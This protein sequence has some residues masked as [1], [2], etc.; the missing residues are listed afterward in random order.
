MTLVFCPSAKAAGGGDRILQSE[1]KQQQIRSTTQR[2]NDQLAAIVGE[3]ERNGIG[4]EDVGV[5]KSIQ[6]V[7]GHLSEKEMAKIVDMLQ[8]ARSA[9]DPNAARRRLLDADSGQKN[10]IVKLKQLM[11]EYKRQQALFDLSMRFAQLAE[12]Q[13]LNMKEAIWLESLVR[14][15]T[16]DR[17]EEAQQ[18]PWRQQVIN[19]EAIR[20][21]VKLALARLD[22]LI[23]QADSASMDRAKAAKHLA[24]NGR[25]EPYLEATLTDLNGGRILSAAGMEKRG[26]DLLREISQQLAPPKDVV[27]ALKRALRELEQAII[28]QTAIIKMTEQLGKKLQE[29]A[30][31]AE[32]QLS[33]SDR[34]DTIRDGVLNSAPSAAAT[35]KE[36]VGK[37]QDAH[38]VL[39][40][41][42]A[43]W[44]GSE[45]KREEKAA[46]D[47]LES[48]RAQLKQQ[49][50]KAE[51]DAK[52]EQ[53]ALA[54]VQDL[55]KQVRA[56]I[57]DQ[58][59]LKEESAAVEA[60]KRL[61]EKLCGEKQGTLKERTQLV[62]AESAEV[63]ERA[64]S[65]LGEAGNQMA[66]AEKSLRKQ[67]NSPEAQKAALDALARAEQELQKELQKLQ[68]SEQE[69]TKDDDSLKRL[70]EIIK[71]QQALQ[72]T[73]AKLGARTNLIQQETAPLAETQAKLSA[74]TSELQQIV[75]T[76]VAT[77]AKLIA[78]A[79]VNMNDSRA[80]LTQ[81]DVKGS[82][83]EQSQALANLFLAKA[84]LEA[85]L[86]ELK[87]DLKRPED[88]A[89]KLAEAASKIEKAQEEINKAMNQMAQQNQKDQLQ[90][91]Q[92]EIADN[93]AKHQQ[94]SPKDATK[95]AQKA[96]QQAADQLAKNDVKAAVDSMQKAQDAMAKADQQQ[97]P[98]DQQNAEQKKDNA[99]QPAQ[100]AKADAKPSMEQLAKQQDDLKQQAQQLAQQQANQPTPDQAMQQAAKNLENAAQAAN[101]AATTQNL[102]PS[103]QNALQQ[104]QNDLAKATGE[105]AAKNAPK[106]QEKA[107]QAQAALSQ[108]SAALA[109]AQAG[110]QQMAQNDPKGQ[111]QQ[112]QNQAGKPD[113]KD[114]QPGQQQPGQQDQ[115]AQQ[116]GQAQ[117]QNQPG[118]PPEKAKGDQGNFD[119]KGGDQGEK[120]KVSGS[121]GFLGLPARDRAAIMQSQSEKY[122]QEYGPMVEQYLKNLSDESSRR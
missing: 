63:S 61:L 39:T 114:K 115:Q 94:D 121:S 86:N 78:D 23:K 52:K 37:M 83:P 109:M 119:G 90:K 80:K 64:S 82:E 117:A 31:L 14:G 45:A 30:E 88:N 70:L 108:A 36:A 41:K 51:E 42:E 6:S 15:K 111:E 97:K 112:Q 87:N 50:T 68:K 11:D 56:L 12:R 65:E 67:V 77:A 28:E 2:V 107:E 81:T 35:L 32:R 3:F 105:A 59:K 60:D 122:P 54:W 48:A 100:D 13:N 66:K 1:L 95:E 44:R 104:A 46:L 91:Q 57:V 110:N 25:L 84:I 96:A 79:V 116:P 49:L 27:D 9:T 16:V 99:Q 62:Q 71:Q 4:G 73:T 43:Q 76:N 85:R 93:L 10:I 26:R 113:A 58:T 74:N 20:D 103:A 22:D 33:L 19:Q 106:A 29:S 38:A 7:L 17:Y 75:A 102:P 92:Q 118:T 18:I 47:R 69:L 72:L 89:Q 101:D 120:R 55:L 53:D 98:Q 24:T 21:E 5:L 8:E 34:T 40:H